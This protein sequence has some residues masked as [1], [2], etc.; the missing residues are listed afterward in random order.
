MAPVSRIFQH[1]IQ[2]FATFSPAGQ[3]QTESQNASFPSHAE[4]IRQHS[5]KT[6]GIKKLTQFR[7]HS[8]PPAGYFGCVIVNNTYS[9]KPW[10][11]IQKESSDLGKTQDGRYHVGGFRWD[12]VNN[13][14]GSAQELGVFGDAYIKPEGV[15][16]V[17]LGIKPFPDKPGGY[18]GHAQLHFEMQPDSPVTDGQ[19]RENH[20]L[21]LS[22]EVHFK[23]GELY[24]P[25]GQGDQPVLYQLG[26]WDDAI[27]KATV[28]HHYPLHLYKLKL[29]Q[30][31]KESLL[32]ER[33]DASIQDH[34][35]DIY[36][37]TENSCLSTL[38]DGVNKVTPEN[39]H[40]KHGEPNSTIPVWCP[41]TFKKY[42]LIASTNPD[43][44]IEAQPKP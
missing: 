31:Q 2:Q 18:P 36:H 38:I 42:H 22:V 3:Q 28:F 19:G 4:Q 10:S 32:R 33:L 1:L 26:S 6:R 9:N 23:Q 11:A 41:K 5:L 16:D 40:I 20:G 39:Q 24:D 15:K 25:V 27:E 12:I 21:V 34:T 37:P 29:T 8:A 43:Q 7:N 14:D 30:E 13:Q 44:I 17:Y 35:Q